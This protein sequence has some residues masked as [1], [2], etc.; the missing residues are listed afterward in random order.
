MRESFF[1]RRCGGACIHSGGIRSLN[2]FIAILSGNLGPI[3][4]IGNTHPSVLVRCI[5][6]RYGRL[7]VSDQ[8][9]LGGKEREEIGKC[10][11]YCKRK[12]NNNSSSRH[13]LLMKV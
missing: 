11:R 1:A 5:S 9:G 12:L 13:H 4:Q 7:R 3:Q 6:D 8:S 10:I 2:S